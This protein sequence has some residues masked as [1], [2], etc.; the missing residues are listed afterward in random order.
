MHLYFLWNTRWFQSIEYFL[1][2]LEIL[3]HLLK[4]WF[5]SFLTSLLFNQYFILII[6]QNCGLKFY[7]S[8][9][10]LS[11]WGHYFSWI[12]FIWFYSNRLSNIIFLD[13]WWSFF[14]I[15]CGNLFTLCHFFFWRGHIHFNL[16][17]R[18]FL[19]YIHWINSFL[20][21]LFFD[22][23]FILFNFI[24][25]IGIL[26]LNLLML[27]NIFWLVF[28]ILH[29]FIINFSFDFINYLRDTLILNINFLILSSNLNFTLLIFLNLFLCFFLIILCF[30]YFLN[31]LI[32]H[33]FVNMFLIFSLDI[34]IL[35]FIF[36]HIIS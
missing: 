2:L 18:F 30:L 4:N 29:F 5:K 31:I 15:G 33:L 34:P 22:N 25:V 14:Y 11:E 20:L 27:F 36:L 8:S 19:L 16:D 13:L 28:F 35:L 26:L 17:C 23:W 3:D 12:I 10:F 7:E 32:L 1:L 6:T 21:L 9:F 24:I